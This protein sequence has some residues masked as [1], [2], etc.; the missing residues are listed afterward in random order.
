MRRFFL[1]LCATFLW[2]DLALAGPYSLTGNQRWIALASRQNMDEAIGIA[3]IYAW[4]LKGVRVMQST[5]GWYAVV[6][7]PH[8]GT[9]IRVVRNTLAN[10]GSVPKDILLSKGDGYVAEVWSRKTPEYLL[11]A[12]YEGGD[13]AQIVTF[14][15]VRMTLSRQPT[16]E[17]DNFY[18]TLVATRAG[19]TIF[20]TKADEVERDEPSSNVIA[21]RLDPTTAFPQFV[22][23]AFTGG[24][25]CCTQTKFITQTGDDWRVIE[26]ALLDADGYWYDDLDGD[27]ALEILSADNSFYYA[28]ASYAESRAPVR[29]A[30]L[31]HGQL[32][33]VT[34][35]PKF[36]PWIRQRLYAMEYEATQD[37]DLWRSNG[38]LAAWVANKALVGEFDQA[39]VKMTISYNSSSD[40]PL[41]ECMAP[42]GADGLC[43]PGKEIALS[44]PS[45]L[46]KHLQAEAYIP[47][48]VA[49][50]PAAAKPAS[51]SAPALP[52]TPAPPTSAFSVPP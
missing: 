16:K 49:A 9:D 19:K 47:A 34:K 26:G 27:G 51:S 18:P 50:P 1:L 43:P 31:R 6:A 11:E 15:D 8:E 38:F 25:H 4:R 41:T 2:A 7:G 33:D 29:I 37:A 40:W 32:Q 52:V 48:D 30:Q 13:Q 12:E 20:E 28:Y 5:N 10:T 35:D 17:N 3:Q 21:L 44:Y 36:A 24:A 45:A 22:F 42:R 46:R 39:W 23:S 14:R